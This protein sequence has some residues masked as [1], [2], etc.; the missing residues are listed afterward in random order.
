MKMTSSMG[1]ELFVIFITIKKK[2]R[3]NK[4]TEGD[5][6]K[7][8]NKDRWML[9]AKTFF[10]GQM[11]YSRPIPGIFGNIQDKIKIPGISKNF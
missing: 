11:L 8:I 4:W 5:K 9:V 7:Y 10:P 2:V 3:R 1:K 6:S